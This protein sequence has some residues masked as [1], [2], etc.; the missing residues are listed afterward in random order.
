MKNIFMGV[1]DTDL[2]V[3]PESLNREE[4]SRVVSERKSFENALEKDGLDD[5]RQRLTNVGVFGLQSPLNYGGKQLIETEL[6]YFNEVISEDLSTALEAGQHNAVVQILN[7]FGTEQLKYKCLDVLSS[8]T[9]VASSALF[10]MEAPCGAMF[11]TTA[12]LDS[13]EDSWLLNGHKSFVINGDKAGYLLVL[14]STQSVYTNTTHDAA[15]TAFL[16]DASAKGVVKSNSDETLGLNDGKQVSVT[17]KNVEIP[18]GT[19]Q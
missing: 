12:I 16:V 5:L 10:E 3:Y 17:F 11:N 19:R 8:G 1:V 6:A 18:K 9:K 4:Q 15:I 14:A 13:S 2:L 7:R